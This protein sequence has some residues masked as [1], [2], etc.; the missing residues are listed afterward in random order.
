MSALCACSPTF[1]VHDVPNWRTVEPGVFRSGQPTTLAEWRWIRAQGVRHVLKL[2]YNREGSD[3]LAT[4]AGLDVHVLSIPPG[5]VLDVFTLPDASTLDDAER[6]L[7]GAR[8]GDGWL[9]H[10]THGQDRTGLV[11]GRLRVLRD[12]WTK[13]KAYDEMRADGFHPELHGLHESWERFTP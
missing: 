1:Y 3:A 7:A 11:V 12:G 10:C 2:N 4:R 8:P 6:L 13:A 9:V 5:G